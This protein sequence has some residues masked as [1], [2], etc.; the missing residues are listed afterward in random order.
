MITIIEPA[1]Y[2][3][4]VDNRR[5]SKFEPHLFVA[6]GYHMRVA[7]RVLNNRMERRFAKF[8]GVPYHDS[9]C[10]QQWEEL[11]EEEP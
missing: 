1:D 9:L 3:I 8:A 7:M 5:Q 2:P 11:W 4:V 6:L 10:R